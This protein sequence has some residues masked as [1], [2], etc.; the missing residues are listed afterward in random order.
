MDFLEYLA[1]EYLVDTTFMFGEP[2]RTVK[3][4]VEE[5]VR[6]VTLVDI[7]YYLLETARLKLEVLDRRRVANK[8]YNQLKVDFKRCEASIYI[9]E[10]TNLQEQHLNGGIRVTEKLIASQFPS[11]ALYNNL[12]DYGVQLASEVELWDNLHS[13]LIT[14]SQRLSYLINTTKTH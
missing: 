13:L 3:F 4:Q 1:T 8:I 9:Q 7:D 5:L 14:V 2:A 6:Q 12:E 10:S 11:Y